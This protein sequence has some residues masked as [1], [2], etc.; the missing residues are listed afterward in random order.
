MLL[1]IIILIVLVVLLFQSV[2]FRL[3]ISHAPSVVYYGGTDFY[4]WLKYHLYDVAPMGNISAYCADFG[5]GKTLSAVH[6]IVQFYNRYNNKKFFDVHRMRWIT[7]KVLVVS[8]VEFSNIPF[9]R[10][11]GLSQLVDLQQHNANIDKL[12]DTRTCCIFFIDEASSQLNSRNFTKN[13]NQSVIG[14]LVTC[15]H[16]NTSLIYTSQ[17]FTHVDKL[18]RDDTQR[19]IQCNKIWRFM[20]HSHY[21]AHVL[22]Y[23]ADPTIVKPLFRNGFFIRNSDYS[24]YDTLALVDNLSH[25]ATSNDFRSEKEII[26]SR[27]QL[28]SDDL[29]LSRSGKKRRHKQ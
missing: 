16:Y 26:E 25:S 10:L 12:N 9:E 8:N 29:P 11:V 4:H 28:L 5:K 13:F 17:V 24:S 3:I 15:R 22:E 14:A 21:N 18:M 2:C 7:Q 19:V 23:A 27:A 20:V 6:Y 1:K